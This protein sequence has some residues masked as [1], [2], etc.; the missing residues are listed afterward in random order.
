MLIVAVDTSGRKGSIA[1]CRGDG[2]YFESLQL[3]SLEGGMYSTQLMPAIS[4]ALQQHQFAKNQVDGFVIVSGPGSFTGLRV[5]LSTVKALCEVLQKPLADVSMLEA[6][7][8]LH[9]RNGESV[10]ALLDA[11]RG[12]LYVGEYRRV[13]DRAEKMREYIAKTEAVMSQLALP[14]R[15]LTP[16]PKVAEALRGISTVVT[17]VEPLQADDVARI[18]LRKLLAGETVDPSILDANYMRRSDAELFSPRR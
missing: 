16:D 9:G 15:I 14:A 12:E 6:I 18:G 17:V 7:A 1:L 8:V 3:T 5:G 13:A 11:G 10:T 4:E 2:S